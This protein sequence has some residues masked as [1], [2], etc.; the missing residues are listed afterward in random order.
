MLLDY[1]VSRVTLSIIEKSF[2]KETR[3]R[4]RSKVAV[5]LKDS[6]ESG[7]DECI[8]CVDQISK[9]GEAKR[10]VKSLIYGLAAMNRKYCIEFQ[11]LTENLG[12]VQE[13]GQWVVIDNKRRNKFCVWM[14]VRTKITNDK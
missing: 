3:L 12:A 11:I 4:F 2:T 5:Y 7:K 6:W 13:N 1:L 14:F 10:L 9:W 8:F